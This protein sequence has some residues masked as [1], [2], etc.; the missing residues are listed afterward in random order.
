[1]RFRDR[2]A[3]GGIVIPAQYGGAE[4]APG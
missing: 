1:V 2:L 3:V 4:F